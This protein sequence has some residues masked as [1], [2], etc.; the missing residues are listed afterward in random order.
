[1]FWISIIVGLLFAWFML[2]RGLFENWVILFNIAI[3]VYVAVFGYPVVADKIP[4]AVRDPYSAALT[5]LATAAA[6]FAVLYGLEYIFF[7]SRFRVSL[8]KLLDKTGS[9][10]FGFLA[11]LLIFSFLV[12]LVFLTPLAGDKLT[13]R[14]GLQKDVKQGNL[15][16]MYFWCDLVN[17][18][19][20]R[21]EH[22]ITCRQAV[23]ELLLKEAGEKSPARY[24]SDTMEPNTPPIIQSPNQTDTDV[25]EKQQ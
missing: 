6:C 11:G 10:I 5:I 4:A 17:K 16:Y 8:P 20:A 19:A 7:V 24:P 15:S 3:S 18:A 21:S 22:K 1:M 25:I 2:K 23:A 13:D 12:F 14:L 9:G